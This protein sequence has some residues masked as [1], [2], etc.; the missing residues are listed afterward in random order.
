MSIKAVCV[1]VG[2]T[3]KGTVNFE[4]QVMHREK[5]FYFKN[6]IKMMSF[7]IASFRIWTLQFAFLVK[8]KV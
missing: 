1:L 3:V 4:Q 2:E 7:F 6:K 5:H 8:S